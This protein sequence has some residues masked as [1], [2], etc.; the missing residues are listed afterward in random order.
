EETQGLVNSDREALLELVRE[1]TRRQQALRQETTK[2]N[3]PADTDR[4][5]ATVRPLVDEQLAIHKNLMQLQEALH[6]SPAVQPLVENA[7]QAAYDATGQLFDQKPEP[8]AKQQQTVLSNLAAIEEALQTA[9]NDENA[10]KTAEE[11]RK[12]V[13]DLEGAREDLRQARQSQDQANEQTQKGQAEE[14]KASE[15]QTAGK[16]A[17]AGEQ[18]KLPAIV[19]SRLA[20]AEA[21]TTE[22][23]TKLAETEAAKPEQQAAVAAADESLRRAES[24]VEAA[25]A[26]AQRRALAVE[27]GE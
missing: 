18:R 21:A 24:E 16:V 5:A 27:I 7:Q 4:A 8:A 6:T 1:L 19:N 13:K 14:A 12:L 2:L 26:D 23:A 17:K 20:E 10:D 3:L 15:E 22:A 25:L 9:A 11:Y